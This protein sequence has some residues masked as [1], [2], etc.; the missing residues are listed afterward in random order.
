[1]PG[2]TEASQD[3][4]LPS[5]WRGNLS[6]ASCYS[7]WRAEERQWRDGVVDAKPGTPDPRSGK[8][9]TPE[10]ELLLALHSSQSGA[11]TPTTAA[12]AHFDVAYHVAIDRWTGGA[13]DAQLYTAL[14]PRDVTWEPLRLE[15]E[16]RVPYGGADD[17][18]SAALALRHRDAS[19]M[20]LL[21]VLDDLSRGDIALGY[22]T[23][24]GAGAIQVERV[25]FGGTAPHGSLL[26]SLAD[27]ADLH[28]WLTK[29]AYASQRASLL[30]TWRQWQD[31]AAQETGK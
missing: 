29:P 14:E 17:E 20:L 16:Q 12:P 15:L 23:R 9:Y 10:S 3:A 4:R 8:T 30:D 7:Y 27:A 6:V 18:P 26:A 13:A 1:M 25:R 28:S 19:L 2:P 11:Q 22:G 21:H 24:R 31:A 5:G